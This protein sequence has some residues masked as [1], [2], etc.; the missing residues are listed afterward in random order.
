MVRA[1]YLIATSLAAV[2]ISL[3]VVGDAEAAPKVQGAQG[4]RF[5]L[6]IDT[7]F[8]GFTHINLD[9]DNGN[10]DNDRENLVGFGI[11][12][13]TL[14]DSTLNSTGVGFGYVFAENRAIVGGRLAL[15]VDGS[16]LGEDIKGTNFRSQFAPYF[17]WMFL[18]GKWIRPYVEGRIG[19]GGGVF[20]TSDVEDNG[21]ERRRVDN[22]LYAFGGPGGGVHLFPVEYFSVD[23]GLNLTLAG[24]YLKDKTTISTG[25]GEVTEENDWDNTA[26]IVNFAAMVGVS[27]WF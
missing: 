17:Q 27:T 15:V 21:D 16:G 8:L 6:H 7:D 13:L 18:P 9:G 26:F 2:V 3:A 12:R 20:V 1:T 22:S 11:G 14:A 19:I 24:S 10:N 23:L 4:K 25:A 5:R